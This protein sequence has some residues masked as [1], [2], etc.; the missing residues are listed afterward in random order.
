MLELAVVPGVFHGFDVFRYANVS[1]SF[2]ASQL[3]ALR[4]ALM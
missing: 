1:R 2:M 4:R 3:A